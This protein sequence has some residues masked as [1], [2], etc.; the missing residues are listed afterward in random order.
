MKIKTLIGLIII[1]MSIFAYLNLYQ[2]GSFLNIEKTSAI[3][4]VVPIESNDITIDI[5]SNASAIGPYSN[6]EFSVGLTNTLDK[7]L[8]DISLN[9][10]AK[11]NDIIIDPASDPLFTVSSLDPEIPTNFSFITKYLEDSSSS[12][13]DLVLLIDASG[14]MQD[15][16]DAVI[17]EL[18]NLIS[19]LTTEIPDLRIGVIVFG[20]A[21]HSE[22]PMSSQYN[23]VPLTDDFSSITSF[24][25]GLYAQGGVEPWGDAFHLANTWDWRVEAAKL[26]ILVGDEDCD[27]GKIIGQDMQS[28]DSYN[29]SDLLDVV[30]E[31]KNKEIMIS[32]VIC[33]G[34]DDLTINQ[35]QWIAEFTDGTSVFLPE[36]IAEGISLPEIIE[37]WTLELGREYFKFFNLTVFWRDTPDSSGDD[38]INTQIETFWLDFTPPSAIISK[39]IT[40]SGMDSYS[41]EFFIEVSDISP[42]GFVTFYH[43]AYGPWTVEYL[44]ALENTSNYQFKLHNVVGGVNLSYFVESSDVL[45][46]AGQSSMSWVIVEP[47]FDEFGEETAFWVEANKTI[48]T[49]IKIQFTGSYYFILSGSEELNQITMDLTVLATN[50]TVLPTQTSHVNISS[51]YG[52]KIFKYNLG[53]GDHAVILSIPSNLGNFSVSYVWI[54]MKQP[55]NNIFTGSMTDLIRAFG[56]EWEASADE[57]FSFIYQAGSP[58]VLRAE[59]YSS[60]WELISTF[61]IGESLQ[62]TKNDTYYILVW[63]TLRTGEF[64]IQL[65]ED[66]P[67]TTYDPYYTYTRDAMAGASFF[68]ESVFTIFLISILT[69]KIKKKKRK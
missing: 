11:S 46:N 68:L 41:V 54:D 19:T 36:L 60:S 25:N 62:L 17:A 56:F 7:S 49:N 31:I 28:S 66:S 37:E 50:N 9:V 48:Y 26:I 16:I 51:L 47:K 18:N 59:V 13:V 14:S 5:T 35:F 24:I 63:A 8:Y 39:M 1:L 52:R 40:P 12:A 2:E 20:W 69:T 23:Y 3:P 27:P 43:N 55:V 32:T 30:T 4:L 29:G 34:A 61:I 22:Y 21:K 15:E 10:S 53:P 67:L 33:G 42:I 6:I 38:F 65:T 58:L 44:T 64:T 45:N 57:Y